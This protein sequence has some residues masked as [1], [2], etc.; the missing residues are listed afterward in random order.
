MSKSLAALFGLSS[1]RRNQRR[2]H[3][4]SGYKVSPAAAPQT[5]VGTP[6]DN[7]RLQANKARYRHQGPT[8]NPEDKI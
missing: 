8:E 5:A 3:P 2:L 7:G 4:R 1:Y 6:H